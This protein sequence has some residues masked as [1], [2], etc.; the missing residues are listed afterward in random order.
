MA[1][2]SLAFPAL[3]AQTFQGA[4][5]YLEPM[6]GS[7]ERL[8]A[9]V[10]VVGATDV[11]VIPSIRPAVIRAM[12]GDKS[13]NFNGLVSLLKES[14]QDH[15]RKWRSFDGWRSPL[16]SACLG[17]IRPLL[18]DDA[19]H[20]LRQLI[21][22][23]AS[24]SAVDEGMDEGED[25]AADSESQSAYWWKAVK[26]QVIAGHPALAT[27]FDIAIEGRASGYQFRIGFLAQGI[28]AHFGLA[29]PDRLKSDGRDLK[30]KLWE[31]QAIRTSRLDVREA[32][33]VLCA[34]LPS[35][36][37]STKKLESARILVNEIQQEAAERSLSLHSVTSTEEAAAF[38][39]QRL[40]A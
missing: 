32:N 39:V 37:Y 36:L 13:L 22:L 7:G 33:L 14:L 5:L 17:E 23:H 12:Y 18:A 30:A 4:P 11:Q 2:N 20:A 26:S 8:T 35:P 16:N 28:A 34:P 6:M 40:A 15:L 38:L 21:L 3:P 25:E 19:Q 27:G 31:L 9:L 1:V 29:R 24:L 10:A